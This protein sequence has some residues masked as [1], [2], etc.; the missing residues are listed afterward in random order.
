M[1]LQK[2]YSFSCKLLQT[3][4]LLGKFCKWPPGFL[5]ILVKGWIWM[6]AGSL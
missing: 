1:L 6:V 4:G 3:A 2:Q 5:C